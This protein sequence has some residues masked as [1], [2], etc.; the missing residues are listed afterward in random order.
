MKTLSLYIERLLLHHDC[1]VVPHFGAF[2]V[3]ESAAT[4]SDHENLFFPP[5]RIVRFNPQLI[6]DDNLLVDAVRQEQQCSVAD[7]K[8]AIQG[9][10]LNLRSQLLADGQVDFGTIGVFT[11]DEDGELA[12]SS[13]QA[14]VTSPR[15]YGLDAFTMPRLKAVSTPHA[16]VSHHPHRRRTIRPSDNITITISRRSL[17]NVAAVAAVALL[18]VLFTKPFNIGDVAGGQ[19]SVIPS[20]PNTTAPT[21]KVV[22]QPVAPV[23]QAPIESSDLQT[24]P[25]TTSAYAVVL[26][27]HVSRKNADAF[28]LRL[29]ESG[30]ANARVHDNGKMLRVVI[31]G[32]T[33]E[34]EAANLAREL[35]ALGGEYKGAWVMKL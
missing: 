9:M 2:V 11:Q 20:V 1:V 28:V 23:E 24:Q 30:Y 10:V 26:A 7:A 6:Q 5:S 8:R 32:L 35:Q 16:A 19:A 17:R 15:Y 31:D 22:E 33:T 4:H 3:R 18:C 25:S 27:S 34:T 12:F 14:G 13:C 21:E 29:H